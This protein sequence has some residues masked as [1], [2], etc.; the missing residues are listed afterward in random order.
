M[1]R[2]LDANV[3]ITAKNSYY[4]LDL[5]LAFWSWLEQ[6]ARSKRLASTDLIYDELKDGGDNLAK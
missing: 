5:V 3:F 6:Q 4:A 1:L 2:L